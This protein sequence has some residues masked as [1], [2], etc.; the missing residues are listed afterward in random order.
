MPP[1]KKNAD[2]FTSFRII[3]EKAQRLLA[4]AK[5]ERNK[6]PVSTSELPPPEETPYQEVLVHLSIPGVVKATFAVF[7]VLMGLLIAYILIDKLVLLFLAIFV[8]TV[9]DPGVKTLSRMGIPRPFA[10]IIHYLIAGFLALFL[11]ISFIPIIASQLQS[12]AIHLNAQF[13]AFVANPEIS[14]PLIPADV[15]AQLTGLVIT[16]LEQLS[17]QQFTDALAQ[18][19]QSLSTAAQGSLALAAQI[20]GSIVNFFLNMFVVLGLAFFLQLEKEH[21]FSWFRGFLPWKY[22][23]Y[24]DDKSEAITWKIGQ[25][26]RGQLILCCTIAA[27]V[28]IALVILRMPYALTLALLAGFTEFIPVVGPFIAAVP[29]VLIGASSKGLLWGVVIALVYYVIQ[30]CENNL[31]VPLIMKRAVG[32]SPT[33]IMFA[34]LV[35]VSFPTVIHPVLGVILSIPTTTV[36]ALFLEDLRDF[37]RK[38]ML[39]RKK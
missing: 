7:A 4:K 26:A 16:T 17:I 34:M 25:W 27:L 13:N 18:F 6:K 2:S 1:S 37:R 14:L 33:A 28:F 9:I 32:L 38:A 29:S 24:L 3:G 20:A 36:I 35:G 11:L 10:I 31:L 39:E 19:G 5:E 15:N 30:W 8:A 21:I 23:T 22:R 12:L